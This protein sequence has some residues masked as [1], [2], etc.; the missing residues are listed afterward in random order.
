MVEGL[1]RFARC[2]GRGGGGGTLRRVRARREVS[3]ESEKVLSHENKGLVELN[4][5]QQVPRSKLTSSRPDSS[6][7]AGS[8]AYR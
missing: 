3:K 8:L 1:S 7:L 2:F 4:A 5:R 6:S